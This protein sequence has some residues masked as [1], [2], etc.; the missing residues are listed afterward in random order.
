MKTASYINKFEHSGK[1]F[2]ITQ[3]CHP[4]LTKNVLKKSNTKYYTHISK[5]EFHSLHLINYE[6]YMETTPTND[7]SA[8]CFS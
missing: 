7:Y 1:L 5:T 2:K 8:F 3:N 6:I 4:F